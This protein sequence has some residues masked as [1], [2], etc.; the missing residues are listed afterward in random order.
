MQLRKLKCQKCG[1]TS[2]F[3]PPGTYRLHLWVDNI[4][5]LKKAILG[6][7][8]WWIHTD[9]VPWSEISFFDIYFSTIIFIVFQCA[10]VNG[11]ESRRFMDAQCALN[12]PFLLMRCGCPY[13]SW[14]MWQMTLR[15]RI[16]YLKNVIGFCM[17]PCLLIVSV[18]TENN[19]VL[20]HSLIHQIVVYCKRDKQLLD[21]DNDIVCSATTITIFFISDLFIVVPH[22]GRSLVS[23]PI[24]TNRTESQRWAQKCNEK[25]INTS[26]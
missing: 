22:A 1:K 4:R 13:D 11:L 9:Y 15:N 24:K 25:P 19:S 23:F 5:F 6:E 8:N 16:R 2:D 3:I 20:F 17:P 14:S 10:T 18:C 26:R 21:N 12:S 7:M